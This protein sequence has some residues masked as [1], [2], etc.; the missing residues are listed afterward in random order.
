MNILA[1]EFRQ[2]WKALED[3][4]RRLSASQ[5]SGKVVEI[6]GDQVRLELE[7]TNPKTGKAFLSPWVKLQDAASAD[8][9]TS[10]SMPVAV[11]DP[12]RLMSPNGE[13]GPL[14]L[15]IRDSH[16]SD[17]ENPGSNDELALVFG[18]GALRIS[19][20]ALRLS[21]GDSELHLSAGS[22][23]LKQGGTKHQL[24]GGASAIT[25]SS[26]NHNGVNVGADHTHQNVMPGGGVS[27][28]PA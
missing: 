12:M 2:I 6:D 23:F 10:S 9:S 17:A 26:H 19:E 24:S 28:V 15:A 4:Q 11:G 13:L 16:T 20:G 18:N 7:P 21:F 8:A 22:A 3:G 14:S 27:G 5:I 25:S 1:R